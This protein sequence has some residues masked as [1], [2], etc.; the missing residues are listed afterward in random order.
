MPLWSVGVEHMTFCSVSVHI[1]LVRGRGRG[2]ASRHRELWHGGAT[3]CWWTSLV[4]SS[5]TLDPLHP[6]QPDTSVGQSA[7]TLTLT[8]A[9]N[10]PSVMLLALALLHGIL[11]AGGIAMFFLFCLLFAPLE[12]G[13]RQY[14][15][16]RRILSSPSWKKKD[17]L[18]QFMCS[19]MMILMMVS[20]SLAL[21]LGFL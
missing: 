19:R 13:R 4:C 17:L 14:L 5:S 3:T 6:T 1:G 12:R 10:S 9:T 18:D 21:V 20:L 2:P 16:H 8:L 15:P 11:T 7:S